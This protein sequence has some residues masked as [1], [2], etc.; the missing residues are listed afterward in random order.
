MEIYCN[1]PY[2][3][4]CA[5][6]T[7]LCCEVIFPGAN[8]Q[9]IWYG[10]PNEYSQYLTADRCDAFAIPLIPFAMRSG[11]NIRCAAPV[12]RRLL[13]QVN[14]YLIPAYVLNLSSTHPCSI[15]AKPAPPVEKSAGGIA[16]GWT[17]GVD[18]LYTLMHGINTPEPGMKLTHLFILNCGTLE[19]NKLNEK[20]QYL[21]GNAQKTISEETGL[22]TVGIDSNVHE[23]LPEPFLSA[24]AF[25]TAGAVFALQKLLKAYLFSST[26]NNASIRYMN[27]D[28]TYNEL[29]DVQQLRTEST[30]I[31]S[32]HKQT[33][34]EKLRELSDFPLA[35]RYLHPCV[36]SLH[37]PNCMHCPKCIKTAL[38]LYALGTLDRFNQVFDT[39]YFHAH[40]TDYIS[41]A[42][43]QQDEFPIYREILNIIDKNPTIPKSVLHKAKLNIHIKKAAYA[44]VNKNK[45][46]YEKLTG[47]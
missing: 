36:R 24:G 39:A 14:H 34:P 38:A 44:A 17:G 41:I 6:Q 35:Y 46:L 4:Y 16:T 5:D 19:G 29:Y 42:M 43:T 18:S 40:E 26:R 9:V 22:P 37:K 47:P 10:L 33:R 32:A 8:K 31:Y 27:G 13:Y 30:V 20:L 23:I 3:T 1:A 45:P 2:I 12:S 21:V 11:C 28:G 25:R 7:R 15:I